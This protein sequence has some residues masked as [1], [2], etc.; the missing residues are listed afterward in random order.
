MRSLRNEVGG[1]LHARTVEDL[2]AGRHQ[3]RPVA[4]CRQ[5]RCLSL[6]HPGGRATAPLGNPDG[7]SK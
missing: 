6:E 2:P 1:A 5:P 3:T 7:L 4:A